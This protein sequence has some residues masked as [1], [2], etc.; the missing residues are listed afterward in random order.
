MDMAEDL[1]AAL[2]VFYI[3]LSKEDLWKGDKVQS[4]VVKMDVKKKSLS[5]VNIL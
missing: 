1:V 5:G 2:G 3:V 4:F